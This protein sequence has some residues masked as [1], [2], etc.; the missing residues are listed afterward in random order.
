M[1]FYNILWERITG[2]SL[3]VAFKNKSLIHIK[4]IFYSQNCC[5]P[6]LALGQKNT[7][8]LFWLPW[9]KKISSKSEVPQN[10]KKKYPFKN[11]TYI[12]VSN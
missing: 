10:I 9:V 8:V 2:I 3:L 1:I 11:T 4:L 12:S 6:F 5:S 7:F